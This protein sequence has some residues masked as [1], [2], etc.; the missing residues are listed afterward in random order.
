MVRECVC[1]LGTDQR[2]A[3]RAEARAAAVGRR[4][5]SAHGRH[6][7]HAWNLSRPLRRHT[8]NQAGAQEWKRPAV[9]ATALV[10]AA[11]KMAEIRALSLSTS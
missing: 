5:M 7:S 1:Y 10:G 4:C 9:T 11:A 6:L 2:S 3:P 8:V